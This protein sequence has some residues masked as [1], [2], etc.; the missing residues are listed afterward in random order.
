MKERW[1][2]DGT[3][4]CACTQ[5]AQVYGRGLGLTHLKLMR[6]LLAASGPSREFVHVSKIKVGSR[7]ASS[8]G[9]DLAK[10][11][12]FGLAETRTNDDE[13]KT[14]SGDWRWAEKMLKLLRGEIEI[15]RYAYVYDGK[16]LRFSDETVGPEEI[17]GR[18]K[19]DYRELFQ[20]LSW[21]LDE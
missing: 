3:H 9:G 20:D 16:V 6:A 14:H 15:P 4:C 13:T 7:D 17:R 12:L 8:Y 5:K 21:V 1:N 11:R 18:K 19:F 2:K 10:L